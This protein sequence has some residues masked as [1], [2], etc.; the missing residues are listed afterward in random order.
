MEKV[1]VCMHEG[2]RTSLEHLLN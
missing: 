1:V 2:K